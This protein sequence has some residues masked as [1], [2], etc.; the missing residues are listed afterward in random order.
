MKSIVVLLDEVGGLI[1][2]GSGEVSNEKAVVVA[3]LAVVLQL[4][5]S[6]QGQAGIHQTKVRLGRL[7]SSKKVRL[8][9]LD[10]SKKVRLGRLDSLNK[11]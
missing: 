11:S 7:D 5:L 1:A 10:S 3:D 6:R 8:A 9:R 4:R 2:N